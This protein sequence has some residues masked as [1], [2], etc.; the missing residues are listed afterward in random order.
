MDYT[1]SIRTVNLRIRDFTGSNHVLS[2]TA[3]L[4]F[5]K[6]AAKFE[7][8][9]PDRA[10]QRRSDAWLSWIERDEALRA[11]GLLGPN[12]ARARLLIRDVLSSYRMGPLTFTNG[13]SFDPLGNHLSI[14]CKLSEKWSITAGC[15]DLFA[16][17]AYRH[18]AL[19]HAVKKRFTSYCT[20]HRYD[21]RRLNRVLWSKLRDLPDP[22]YEVF[23]FKLD[24]SVTY[25]GGNRWSTVP[26]NNLKDRSIC[27]EPLCNMLVQRA[28]GLGIRKCLKDRLGIDLDTLAD[29]HRCRISDPSV[30]TIDLS[31]CSDTIS[32]DLVEYL[33]P[34]RVLKHILACR[35][36]MTLGPDDNFY[37]VNKVSS[38]GNG[39]TFDLM[40]LILTAL[41]KSLDDTASSFGDDI[42][43]QNR[44]AGELVSSLQVAGFRPN[45]EKTFIDSDYRE[46]CGAHYIDGCGYV[47]VFDLRWLRTPH[48]LVV[49]C[50]KAAI[51]ADIYG[52]PFEEL[53]RAI[54]TCVP[55]T[56]LGVATKRH[57]AC[58]N[59]PPSYEL[60]SFVRY[61]PSIYSEPSKRDLK[62]VRLHCRQTQKSGRI[63]TALAFVTRQNR[64]KSSIRSAEWDIYFQYLQ[65]G[66][67]TPKI[68][69]LEVKSTSVARVDEENIGFVNALPSRKRRK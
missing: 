38:M 36:D 41:A 1:G 20:T 23:K 4:A 53:R 15:F 7:V 11:R 12:W 46:S 28:V 8:P 39:F 63:S 6:L 40:S 66:R 61:G 56:L 35:S 48:D 52:G 26:K 34:H 54:W 57:V 59:R 62:V 24:C 30:A 18:R 25:V 33:L 17:Y 55:Q 31:D 47:T 60:S 16:E 9:T 22:A 42:I 69:R 32:T 3:S 50:N 65:S 10:D 44:V 27:L 49:A 5:A 2:R 21:E 67:L 19:K 43:C 64:A 13:S 29:V 68:P 45:V 14:A 58:M 37:I 51:L